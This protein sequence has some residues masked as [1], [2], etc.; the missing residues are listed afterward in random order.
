VFCSFIGVDCH[1]GRFLETDVHDVRIFRVGFI[2]HLLYTQSMVCSLI[3]TNHYSVIRLELES[4]NKYEQLF[5]EF[6]KR[7]LDF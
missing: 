4:K 5:D 7:D 3:L 6:Y 2:P 1:G